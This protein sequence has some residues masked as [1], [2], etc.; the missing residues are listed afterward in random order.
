[1]LFFHINIIS[2]ITTRDPLIVSTSTLFGTEMSIVL[3]KQSGE[4]WNILR[5][6]VYIGCCSVLLAH[7]EFYFNKVIA[8]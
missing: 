8:F 3:S 1:M 4:S 7:A 6:A 2:T 5:S